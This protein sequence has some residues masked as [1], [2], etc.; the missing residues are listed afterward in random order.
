MELA[1]ANGRMSSS[2]RRLRSSSD[3]A[4]DKTGGA[5]LEVRA[6]AAIVLAARPQ[7]HNLAPGNTP[8]RPNV[9]AIRTSAS[10]GSSAVV[11]WPVAEAP[12]ESR[13]HSGRGGDVSRRSLGWLLIAIAVVVVVRAV[14]FDRH[15]LQAGELTLA[16]AALVVGA[17]IVISRPGRR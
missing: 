7:A 14:A 16:A 2:R 11:V 6:T 1:V 4:E 8:G 15:W 17:A 10:G 12:P 13:S 5:G 9:L 3:D